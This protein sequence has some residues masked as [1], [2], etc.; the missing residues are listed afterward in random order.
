[1]KLPAI[2]QN[3]FL[4]NLAMLLFFIMIVFSCA[5]K[6]IY[7]NLENNFKGAILLLI[8]ICTAIVP[9]YI[10]MTISNT[11]VVKKLFLRK[12]YPLFVLTFII[13]W[14]F[15]HFILLWYFGKS[16]DVFNYNVIST[17][18]AL[19][20]G[21]GIYFLHIWILKN[22]AESR[23]EV[24]NFE[25]E[26]S[27]LKQ[28]LNPHFLLN[29]MNNLYGESLSEPENVPFRI[30]NLSHMLRYQIEASKKD[31]VPLTEEI[32]FLKRYIEYYS[33]Q[34][35]RLKVI[36]KYGRELGTLKVPPLFFLPLVE[37]AIKFSS[38]TAKPII[39]LDLNFDEEKLTFSLRNN[40]LV[41]GSRLYG[42]GIGI[43]NLK[44]RLEVYDI[45]HKLLHTK[46]E[47]MY[48]VNFLIWELSTA[49]L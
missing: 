27:F 11:L 19:A 20:H 15:A 16:V 9:I 5:Y 13:Y 30:L 32:E 22:I 2:Y 35:E 1:M 38:E 18:S 48:N 29:A 21:T 41:T 31:L 8:N 6:Y 14:F 46:E 39:F 36:Q 10:L 47:D 3:F 49:A 40:Y 23:K 26:L 12:K 34:N 44:R 45:R 7:T 17:I 33:F 28:Q 43:E 42:T 24:I 25:S 4:R 37:N